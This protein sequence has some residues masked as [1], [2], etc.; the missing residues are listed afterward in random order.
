M[1]EPGPGASLEVMDP[2]NAPAPD[3]APAERELL[4]AADDAGY[5]VQSGPLA[6]A[7]RDLRAPGERLRA[8]LLGAQVDVADDVLAILGDGIERLHALREGLQGDLDVADAVFASLDLRAVPLRDVLPAA[9]V[10]LADDVWAAIGDAD[11]M[12]LSAFGDGELEGAQR[13][14]VSRTALR[15]SAAQEQLQTQARL[16]V[17]VRDAAVSG[18]ADVDLWGAIGAS[19][20]AEGAE[21]EADVGDQLRAAVAALPPVD[22]TRGV[23]AG[24]TPRERAMPRWLAIGG[25]VAALLMAA[26]VLLAVVPSLTMPG[27]KVG[28]ASL[29]QVAAPFIMASVN[30]AQVE[31][32]ETATDVVAQVVQF[33]DGGPTFILIDESG[34]SGGTL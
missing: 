26:V 27:V 7:V 20:G 2:S 16:G 19:I 28:G 13:S 10:G 24:I 3:L 25:P 11:D 6:A 1:N 12:L 18:A 31:D 9:P 14:R 32:L 23:M 29:A 22:I 17:Q 34:A 33:D 8:L 4:L 15:Q 21:A 30:D 5:D